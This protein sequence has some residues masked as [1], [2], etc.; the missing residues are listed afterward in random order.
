MDGDRFDHF[1]RSL[2][3]SISRRSFV[4]GISTLLAGVAVAVRPST[5]RGAPNPCNAYCAGEPGARGAQCRQA[6][7]ACGGPTSDG[8]CH[9]QYNRQYLC[10]P[11][12]LGC[13]EPFAEEGVRTAICC[14]TERQVCS[15]SNEDFYCCPDGEECWGWSL[16]CPEGT[17]STCEGACCENENG[18][19]FSL[20]DDAYICGENC[21]NICADGQ[22]DCG[23]ANP[24]GSCAA[25]TCLD[26][27]ED[28]YRCG[29]ADADGFCIVERCFNVCSEQTDCSTPN[30]RGNCPAPGCYD[31]CSGKD[32]CGNRD[33]YG[34][35]YGLACYDPE[36]GTTRCGTECYD[37][38]AGIY[39]C[40]AT[41]Q[42]P[43]GFCNGSTCQPS[44]G[45][46]GCGPADDD[47][48]CI[49]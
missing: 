34:T 13:F 37:Y 12:G 16:C 5:A 35:C 46:I 28:Y 19:C 14:A 27:C 29:E 4:G 30:E 23:A 49:E 38:C 31:P 3:G 24:D 36:L 47:G 10:C 40:G 32:I 26:P 1:T 17:Q 44:T 11:D 15:T 8:F 20:A 45:G 22:Y 33:P 42:N 43:W 25:N 2:A 41:D 39:R 48:N 7:K 21:Y 9:D 6:C 18:C